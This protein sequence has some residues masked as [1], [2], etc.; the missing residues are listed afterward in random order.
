MTKDRELGHC[1]LK[2]LRHELLLVHE[3][4]P[5]AGGAAVAGEREVGLQTHLAGVG[6][7]GQRQ[8]RRDLADVVVG[9]WEPDTLEKSL[10]EELGIEG[11]G[12]L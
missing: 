4:L 12:R 10:K 3:A 7:V 6:A 1:G 5:E 9:A 2:A 11:E 8:R